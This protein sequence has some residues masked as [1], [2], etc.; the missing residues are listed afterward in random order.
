MRWPFTPLTCNRHKEQQRGFVCLQEFFMTL[1]ELAPFNMLQVYTGSPSS[2]EPE[3]PLGIISA[4]TADIHSD[5]C[6]RLL[7]IL[8]E[9]ANEEMH[10]I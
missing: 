1:G 7:N 5:W 4:F 3:V 2:A 9:R 6:D 10:Q 8:V